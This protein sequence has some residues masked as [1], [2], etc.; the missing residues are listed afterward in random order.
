MKKTMFRVLALLALTG[1]A[2]PPIPPNYSGPVA[3]IRDTAVSETSNRAK[4]FYLSE[5]DGQAIDNVLTAKRSGSR[6]PRPASV[7]S[8]QGS[9]TT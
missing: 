4:F 3:T 9:Q 6:K 5:I 8:R 7:S 2:T 1:C